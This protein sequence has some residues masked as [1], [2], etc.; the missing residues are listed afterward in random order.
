M[1]R[2]KL[3]LVYACYFA[4]IIAIVTLLTSS[5]NESFATR[6]IPKNQSSD[7]LKAAKKYLAS[8]TTNNQ[9]KSSKGKRNKKGKG[10]NGKYIILTFDDGWVSQYS[11]YK[12]MKPLKGTLYINSNLIGKNERLNLDNLKEMYDNGWDI[13]NHTV[14]HVNL[15]KVTLEKAQEELYGCSLW[16]VEHGFTRNMAFRHFAYPEGGYNSDIINILDKQNFLTARTT[17][18]GSNTS[19]LLQLGRNSLSGMSQKNI[20]DLILSDK[21]LLI[22]NFHRIIPDNSQKVEQIDLKESYFKEVLSSI[23]KSKRKVLTL[24]EW[25]QLNYLQ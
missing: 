1:N 10:L 19:N 24:T 6:D 23:K 3:V 9:N 4:A 5:K 21:K 18:A 7:E 17:I 25:Y 22:L 12:L 16:L 14:N 8:F 15:T 13:A 20:S 11:A 2:V